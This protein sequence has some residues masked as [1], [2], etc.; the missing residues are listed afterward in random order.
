MEET[1]ESDICVLKQPGYFEQGR[2]CTNKHSFM[3]KFWVLKVGPS[4]LPEKFWV[5][6]WKLHILVHLL[7]AKCMEQHN[8]RSANWANVLGILALGGGT[9]THCTQAPSPSALGLA[10]PMHMYNITAIEHVMK[11]KEKTGHMLAV[12]LSLTRHLDILCKSSCNSHVIVYQRECK[13]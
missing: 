3:S 6:V 5:F 11:N 9:C 10:L 7:N 1:K 13:G 12:I 4:L 2:M 8:L